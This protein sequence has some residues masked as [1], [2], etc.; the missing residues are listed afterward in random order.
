MS[1][2]ERAERVDIDEI[3]KDD[4]DK[5]IHL[6]MDDRNITD[7]CKVSQNRWYNC[8]QYV[9]DNVFKINPV[10]L[11]DDNHISNQYDIDKV[12]KVLDIYIRLCNDYEKVINIVGFTFLLAYIEIHLTD[13]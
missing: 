12:N 2:T 5:Y 6:W 13:G 4:I 11:K 9:C 1:D 10:Y 7:M 8:C 3:Y